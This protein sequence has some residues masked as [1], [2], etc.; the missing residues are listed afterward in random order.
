MTELFAVINRLLPVRLVADCRATVANAIAEVGV[1]AK[2]LDIVGLA[3]KLTS[4]A[5][6]IGDASL[7]HQ[8]VKVSKRKAV[9][10]CYGE[11]CGTYTTLRHLGE[12][13]GD[14]SSSEDGRD[15]DDALHFD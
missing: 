3:M 15:D 4:F 6:H 10:N 11:D 8:E 12:V 5:H 7:L 14:S 9:K 2:A 1:V 13:L